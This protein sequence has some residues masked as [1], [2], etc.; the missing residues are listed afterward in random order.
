MP[1]VLAEATLT[2]A[3]THGTSDKK[4]LFWLVEDKQENL[5]LMDRTAPNNSAATATERHVIFHLEGYEIEVQRLTIKRINYL[6]QS[7]PNAC[8]AN[9]AKLPEREAYSIFSNPQSFYLTHKLYRYNQTS[10]M[11]ELMFNKEN[12][13]ISL[14]KLFEHQVNKRIGLVEGVSYG[15]FLDA[16]VKTLD[17]ANTYYRNGSQ[18]VVALESMLYLNRLDYLLALPVDMTPT[19]EQEAKLEQYNI[20]GAPKFVIAHFSCSKNEFGQQV[21]N[22]INK[23][24]MK[25]YEQKL[26]YTINE[27]W[28]SNTDLQFIQSY[29]Q[30]NYLNS[31]K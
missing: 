4:K 11:P 12:E 22:D 10:P 9:R 1:K 25:T 15:S 31:I 8:V 26:F 7:R 27:K 29:L 14:G 20:A 28:Y 23:I 18:R 13:L 3:L 30:D 6:M 21:I 16:Q 19:L 2:S 5:G 17:K 24:L